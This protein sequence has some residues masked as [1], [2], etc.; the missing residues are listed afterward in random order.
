MISRPR[1]APIA[2]AIYWLGLFIVTHLPPRRV[3]TTNVN[4]KLEH[5]IAYAILATILFLAI[6]RGGGVRVFATVVGICLI[7]GAIDEWTQLLVGRSCEL[8]DWL[9]DASG[10]IVAATICAAFRRFMIRDD[11][12]TEHSGG[13]FAAPP[14][15]R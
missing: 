3:P 2:L 11:S 9:A 12:S 5:F 6:N 7:Y 1:L 10:A 4:D 14:T 8:N 13:E 15:Q